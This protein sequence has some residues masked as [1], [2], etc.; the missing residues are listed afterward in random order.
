MEPAAPTDQTRTARF[1][2]DIGAGLFLLA[3]SAFGFA[4]AAAT[5]SAFLRDGCKRW[6][7]FFAVRLTAF[8]AAFNGFVARRAIGTSSTIPLQD[9]RAGPQVSSVRVVLLRPME[10]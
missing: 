7:I 1:P 10:D 4:G 3:I 8:F 5:L 6:L 2:R 9:Q